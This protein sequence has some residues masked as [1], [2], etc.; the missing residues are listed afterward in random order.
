MA[1]EQPSAS[2][3]QTS[4]INRA[5]LVKMV[6]FTVV[7]LGFGLWGLYDAMLAYPS[8]G[9]EYADYAKWRYLDAA[10]TAG[11]L[12][13]T[14]EMGEPV[15]R[16][17]EL[18]AKAPR[19]DLEQ[20]ELDWLTALARVGKLDPS[21]TKVDGPNAVLDQMSVKWKSQQPPPPLQAYDLPLQWSFVVIGFGLGAVVILNILRSSSKKYTWEA[22]T[23][24]LTLPDGRRVTPEMLADVDKRKWHKYFCTLV[25]ND[26]APSAEMDLLKYQG[27]EEWVLTLE[28][29]RFPDRAAEAEA[30]AAAAAVEPIA[31]A[32][33]EDR[34][35]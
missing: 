19:T 27:L 10:K 13:S 35:G 21:E 31:E 3:V 12:S 29:V 26:G 4:S 2:N 20:A 34:A 5:W 18:E 1:D 32:P 23:T 30:E 24:T 11:K 16:R 6:I 17:A 33:T 8:R 25:F 28:R 9:N 7:L 15:A 22:A 14:A